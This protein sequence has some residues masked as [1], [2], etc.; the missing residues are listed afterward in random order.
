[1]DD[2]PFDHQASDEA[3][4]RDTER[5]HQV[6]LRDW[7]WSQSLLPQPPLVITGIAGG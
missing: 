7:L 1:M 2:L 6:M 3:A 4:E 5:R